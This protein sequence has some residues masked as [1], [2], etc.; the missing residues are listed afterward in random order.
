MTGAADKPVLTLPDDSSARIQLSSF[1]LR[2]AMTGAADKPVLTLPDDSS[3]RIQ[4][5]AKSHDGS[6][7]QAGADPSGRPF[8]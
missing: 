4:Q 7:R 5:F 8:S 6:G 2:R 1:L 3:A